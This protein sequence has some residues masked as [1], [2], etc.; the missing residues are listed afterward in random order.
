MIAAMTARVRSFIAAVCLGLL[1]L[2][3]FA[4]GAADETILVSRQS[5]ADGG[6][7]GDGNSEELSISGDGR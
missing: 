5:S 7:G 6:A 3:S 1:A 4:E 2:A